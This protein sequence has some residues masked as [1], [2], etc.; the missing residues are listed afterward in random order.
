M[1]VADAADTTGAGDAFAAALLARL[2]D[3][4]WPPSGALV[5]DALDGATAAAA[6]VVRV[7]GAQ[8]RTPS[9]RGGTLS[10]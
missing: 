5:R 1:P 3:T 10:R 8:G 4:E 7:A 2:A 6:E 9:E